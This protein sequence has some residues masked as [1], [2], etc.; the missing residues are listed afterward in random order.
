MSDRQRLVSIAIGAGIGAVVGGLLFDIL[1]L[2]DG[3]WG[4]GIGAFLGVFLA[5]GLGAWLIHR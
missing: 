5:V 3:A 2:G 1:A 4:S